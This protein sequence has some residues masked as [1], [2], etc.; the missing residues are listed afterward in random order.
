MAA[1]EYYVRSG[2]N[3]GWVDNDGDGV[4]DLPRWEM[5]K[6]KD[7]FKFGQ[8]NKI[9]TYVFRDMEHG[10]YKMWLNDLLQWHVRD[11]RTIGILPERLATTDPT[12]EAW[13]CSGIAL[14]TQIG[15]SPKEAYFDDVTLSNEPTLI[16]PAL[17]FA[18]G[19]IAGGIAGAIITRNPIGAIVGATLGGLISTLTLPPPPHRATC[20]RCGKSFKVTNLGERVG[21]P[22]CRTEQVAKLKRR[23]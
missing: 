1:D 9:T 23:G 16:P 21:C 19:S 15:S 7:T 20:V 6:S 5:V 4:N 8:W 12:I 10:V 14:Y 17:R 13:I 11:K 2:L 3:H 22:Y 18:G